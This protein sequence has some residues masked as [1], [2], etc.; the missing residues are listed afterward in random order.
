MSYVIENDVPVRGRVAAREN[1]S[2]LTQTISLLEVGQ[3]FIAD[4]RAKGT[5]RRAVS[6]TQKRLERKY[7]TRTVET[8]DDGTTILRIWRI[9]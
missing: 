6:V 9:A 1:M 5:V 3:S 8:K 7:S 4:D 2:E